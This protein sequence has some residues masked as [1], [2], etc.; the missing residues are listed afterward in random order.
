MGNYF[1][2]PD[3]QLDLLEPVEA[4]RVIDT[5]IISHIEPIR[6]LH[7]LRNFYAQISNLPTGIIGKIFLLHQVFYPSSDLFN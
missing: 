1:K 4:R 2:F 7:S 6:V 5:E 3:H